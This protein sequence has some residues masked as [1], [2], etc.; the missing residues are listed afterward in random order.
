VCK[1]DSP[2]D[3]SHEGHRATLLQDYLP[4]H[5]KHRRTNII[6]QI[7]SAYMGFVN[8]NLDEAKERFCIIINGDSGT[9]KTALSK[10]IA[11]K[12]AKSGIIQN[13]K[14]YV[15]WKQQ[16]LTDKLRRTN[17]KEVI[18]LEDYDG[19]NHKFGVFETLT[20][21]EDDGG[22]RVMGDYQSARY[23]KGVIV[24]TVDAI[25]TWVTS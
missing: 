18:M 10:K 3:W 15:S 8:L 4:E 12:L 19:D 23:I 25:E 24:P 21:P 1:K 14:S 22:L 9:H 17:D 11:E 5:L 7:D 20:C 13:S 2:W 6:R 16:D